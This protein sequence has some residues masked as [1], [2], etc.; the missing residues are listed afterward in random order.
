[1]TLERLLKLFPTKSFRIHSTD[2]PWTTSR[3]TDGGIRKI[4]YGKLYSKEKKP[5]T[6]KK[7]T[8]SKRSIPVCGGISLINKISGRS[9]NSTQISY[10]DEGGNVISGNNLAKRVNKFYISTTSIEL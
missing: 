9:A 7:L 3:M 8:I 4:K 10:E 5:S 6:P 2:R 1:M